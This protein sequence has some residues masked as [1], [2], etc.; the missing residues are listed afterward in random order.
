MSNLN[1]LWSELRILVESTE[2]DVIKN[3]S[4]NKAAG[5]RARRSLRLIKN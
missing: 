2:V 1:D 5:V 4:G 3:N